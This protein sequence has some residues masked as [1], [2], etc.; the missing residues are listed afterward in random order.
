[1][2]NEVFARAVMAERVRD[3]KI[4]LF[5]LSLRGSEATPARR[6]SLRSFFRPAGARSALRQG[7]STASVCTVSSVPR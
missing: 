7:V 2:L 1:M 5:L 3:R 4:S 6:R